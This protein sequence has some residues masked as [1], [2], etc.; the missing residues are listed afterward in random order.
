MEAKSLGEQLTKR[1]KGC[2]RNLD[3][4]GF[5]RVKQ[6][7]KGRSGFLSDKT[8]ARPSRST[9]AHCRAVG[10]SSAFLGSSG[11]H[12]VPRMGHLQWR[13]RS[14]SH[15]PAEHSGAI[16]LVVGTLH[17]VRKSPD[18][19]KQCRR[20]TNRQ[21]TSPPVELCASHSWNPLNPGLAPSDG[22]AKLFNGLLRRDGRWMSKS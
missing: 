22:T 7:T 3:K 1:A 4:P 6:G 15:S 14:L 18:Y 12:C 10:L 21:A 9:H 2:I 17:Q 19:R 13:H 8:Q 20:A 5:Q 16:S 11:I